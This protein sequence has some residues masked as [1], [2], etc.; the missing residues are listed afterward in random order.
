M[1]RWS[2]DGARIA[3][4]SDDGTGMNIYW[5]PPTGGTRRK[6]AQTHLQYL[7]RFTSIAALGS[8]PWSPDGRRLVFSKLEPNNSVALWTA[9][10]ESGRETR[11]TTPQPGASDWR[12]A[13]SHDG[14]QVAFSRAATGSPF[15][16][17]VVAASGGEPRAVFPSETASRGAAAWSLD[18]RSLLFVP[19]GVWGGDLS[20]VEIGTGTVKQLTV[21]ASVSTPILSSTG[22]IAFS[23]W[24]H[25]TFSFRMPAANPAGEHTQ[26]SLSG[27][28]NFGQRF[29]PDGRQIVFQSSRGGRSMLWLHDM[30]T[31]AERQLTYPP[32]GREDRTP[33][34]S[35]DGTQVVFLS[36]RGG[37]FQLWVAN[38]DGGATRR[39]SEQAIP[40]DGDWWVNARVAPRWS[41]DGRAIAYLAPGERGSTLW[42]I[43]PDGRNPR[44]TGVS[45]VLRFDWYMDS[46]RAIY[47]RNGADGRIELIA[48][49]V[50]TGEDRVLLKANATELSV[51]PGG[52]A[53][54][55][56][57]ADGHFSINR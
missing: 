46:R 38:V 5:V 8:Q 27:G 48:I 2:P 14:T 40:M 15:N 7:D 36:N 32:A 30:E 53:V 50:E 45:G 18:D 37:P 34:W 42:R 22:R 35:P 54:A 13:W 23:R 28:D 51:A 44:P 49:N 43:D 25:S 29:S 17:Y 16:L 4:L 39:L 57:S 26:I 55:Y 24:S 41:S 11:L 6:I 9:D 10:L 12:G 52:N 3:F 31:G 20:E 56:N 1:P 19:S 33:D 21:G 47:T